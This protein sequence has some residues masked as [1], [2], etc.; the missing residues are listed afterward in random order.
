MFKTWTDKVECELFV[1]IIYTTSY[2]YYLTNADI[3]YVKVRMFDWCHKCSGFV[4]HCIRRW[5]HISLL[6]LQHLSYMNILNIEN[7]AKYLR[8]HF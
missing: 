6:M 1:A 4:L 7:Y 3:L 5:I 2:L 8:A